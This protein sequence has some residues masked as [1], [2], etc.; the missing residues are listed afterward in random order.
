MYLSGAVPLIFHSNGGTT[1]RGQ[2]FPRVFILDIYF[3]LL[4]FD[5]MCVCLGEL[6]G[7]EGFFLGFFWQKALILLFK[8]GVTYDSR[9]THVSLK[10]ALVAL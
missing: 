2:C 1:Y 6:C 5:Y 7:L 10:A 3:S 4:Y 8:P 9:A